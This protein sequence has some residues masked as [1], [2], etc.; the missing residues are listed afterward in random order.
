MIFC[1]IHSQHSE[2]RSTCDKKLLL[3]RDAEEDD[4]LKKIYLAPE[5]AVITLSPETA[6]FCTT[7]TDGRCARA[8]LCFRAT[9]TNSSS[10]SAP[11]AM[12]LG[13][14]RV[15]SASWQQKG[16]AAAA[17]EYVIVVVAAAARP[18]ARVPA[19]PE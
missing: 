14:V 9:R 8:S 10:S 3:A 16:V 17:V 11:V 18:P 2:S 1:A 15:I 5:I 13:S 12:Q 7:V 4:A 6:L 19:R